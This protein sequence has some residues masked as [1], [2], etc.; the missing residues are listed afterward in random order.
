VWSRGRAPYAIIHPPENAVV[1][2]TLDCSDAF[3]SPL[4]NARCGVVGFN[5]GANMHLFTCAITK[6]GGGGAGTY[7]FELMGGDA[8]TPLASL[9][10]DSRGSSWPASGVRIRTYRNTSTNQ[11]ACAARADVSGSA[12]WSGIT[13]ILSVPDA[14][15]PPYAIGDIWMGMATGAWGGGTGTSATAS[16]ASFSVAVVVPASPPA[17]L[18][19]NTDVCIA[20]GG[21]APM[22]MTVSAAT[23]PTSAVMKGL[24]ANFP[25]TITVVGTEQGTGAVSPPSDPVQGSWIF[26]RQMPPRRGGLSLW[27]DSSWLPG[28]YLSRWPDASGHGHHLLQSNTNSRPYVRG[29]DG[30]ARPSIA[31]FTRS[32][33]TYMSS[34]S[35]GIDL[36]MAEGQSY[37]VYLVLRPLSSTYQ[38][39]AGRGTTA[40]DLL[41]SGT[42]GWA[43]GIYNTRTNPVPGYMGMLIGDASGAM[44][45]SNSPNW[46]D[47]SGWQ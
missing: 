4:P 39:V 33:G 25:Y 22:S 7:A 47:S 19:G 13:A 42:F 37:T 46:V 6:R 26:A 41:T 10:V 1:E 43:A 31:S 30:I 34:G 27:L 16:F 12:D 2:T 32:R 15:L 24:S 8:Q 3:A 38:V 9:A 44:S 28:G 40:S 20:S 45:G 36:G 35:D 5:A 23:N 29:G 21:V 17:D 18:Y 11:W 14:L